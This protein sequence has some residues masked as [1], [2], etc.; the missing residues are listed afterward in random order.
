MHTRIEEN[1]ET[2]IY[3]IIEFQNI[4]TNTFFP[5]LKTIHFSYKL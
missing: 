2:L 5:F 3:S 4:F 1:F